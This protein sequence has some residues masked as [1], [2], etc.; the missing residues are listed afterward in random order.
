MPHQSCIF[1]ELVDIVINLVD[2]IFIQLFK[3]CEVIDPN[4]AGGHV[5]AGY[6]TV[7]QITST[8][9]DIL[10]VSSIGQSWIR[11][12]GYLLKYYSKAFV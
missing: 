3:Q 1:A 7:R 10:K 9:M 11:T 4:L 12:L 5:I 6:K 8:E 2:K